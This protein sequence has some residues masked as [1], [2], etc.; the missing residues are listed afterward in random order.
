MNE[1]QFR[2]LSKTENIILVI[3]LFAILFLAIIW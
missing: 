1:P 3:T 2:V